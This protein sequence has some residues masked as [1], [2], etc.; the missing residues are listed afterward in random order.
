MDK[1][2]NLFPIQ[3]YKSFIIPSKSEEKICNDFF[4][5]VFSKLENNIW[6]G[7]S[8][9][10]TGYYH[11]NL[12][13]QP[14]F[15]WLFNGMKESLNTYWWNVLEYHN[16]L[17]PTVTSSWANMHI[18]GQSTAEH[19]H[20]DGYDGLNHISGVY[21]YK[22]DQEESNIHFINPLDSLLRCQPYQQMKGIEDI[23]I[24]ICSKQYD[25]ILFPSWLK[26][27]VPK[28]KFNNPR[29]AISFNCRGIIYG[30]NKFIR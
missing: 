16:S 6:P 4:D 1:V 25:L 2:L 17:I 24:D 26:H 14:E 29:I 7:E 5:S 23:S 13:E 18:I 12:H 30:T 20:M 9:K 15:S 8:G 11:I 28:N 21:Y 19:C 10:S 22:K 3:L 27:K